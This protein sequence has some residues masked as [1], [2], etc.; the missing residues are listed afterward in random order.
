MNYQYNPQPQPQFINI[1]EV[2]ARKKSAFEAMADKMAAFFGTNGFLSALAN[3]SDIICYIITGVG[4]FMSIIEMFFGVFGASLAIAALIFGVM[5]VSKKSLVP[6]SVALSYVTLFSL[7]AFIATLVNLISMA[8]SYWFDFSDAIVIVFELIFS[9]VEFAVLC[10]AT[11]LSWSY[12][13][14]TRPP[15]MYYAYNGQPAP[16]QYRQPVQQPA[17]MQQAAPVQQAAPAPV[18]QVTP[19]PAPVQQEAPAPAPVQQEAPAPAPVQQE[20]PAPVPQ[21]APAP[22]QQPAADKICAACG[23]VNNPDSLFCKSCGNKLS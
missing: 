23:T 8:I 16:Q 17:P 22:V 20:A 3:R 1:A 12:F 15:R 14:A 13:A 9:L 4:L 19:A 18:Q 21:P 11:I 2:N 7:I 10:T 5:A 6:L